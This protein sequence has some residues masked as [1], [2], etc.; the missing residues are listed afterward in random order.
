MT[1]ERWFNNAKTAAMIG[2][3]V[4]KG[5][6]RLGSV[7]VKGKTIVSVGTNSY[8]THPLLTRVTQYPYLHAE[9]QAL[10]RYGL[11]NCEGLSLYV[12]RIYKDNRFALSKPCKTCYNFIKIAGIK[13]VYYTL[14]C[15][16]SEK[17]IRYEYYKF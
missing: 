6:Y 13:K 4:K 12:C 10:F 8:K 7:I 5:S 1:V 9:Q 17:G 3:G 2:S 14:D 15:S 16:S 11:D